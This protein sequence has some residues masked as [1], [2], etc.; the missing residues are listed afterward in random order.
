[1]AE[2]TRPDIPKCRKDRFDGRI[3]LDPSRLVFIDETWASTNMVRRCGRAPRG[4]S[5][6]A[7]IPPVHWKTTTL[8]AGLSLGGIVAPFVPDRP[9]NRVA[10]ESYFERVLVF[11]AAGY[12]AE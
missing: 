3:D 9:I 12:N 10:F 11:E 7:A 5:P 8:I 6:R 1:M 4:Q 2:Q